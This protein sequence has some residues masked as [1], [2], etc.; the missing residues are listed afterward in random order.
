MKTLFGIAL[1]LV[2]VLILVT[3]FTFYDYKQKESICVQQVHYLNDENP[4]GNYYIV[5][6]AASI[7]DM[8]TYEYFGSY[9]ESMQYCMNT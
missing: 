3:G 5:Q 9:E 1:S 8:P 4:K 6:P 2:V 7:K